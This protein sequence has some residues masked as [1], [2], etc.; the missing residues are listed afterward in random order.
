M[1]APGNHCPVRP[2]GIARAGNSRDGDD[3]A[4]SRRRQRFVERVSAPGGDR[5]EGQLR[6]RA[7]D[8]AHGVAGDHAIKAEI[9]CA[10]CG[11]G[12]ARAGRSGNVRAVQLPLITR[13]G[14]A[15]RHHVESR[16]Q[17]RRHG[18]ANR[19]RNNGRR[20]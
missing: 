7:S 6:D 15:C 17:T 2:H 8:G 3:I 16:G 1:I 10:D 5:T 12:V 14:I 9:I 13:R 11:V 4:Q 18:A 19:L 20:S